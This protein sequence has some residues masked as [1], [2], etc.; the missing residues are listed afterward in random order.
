MERTIRV[1]DIHCDH[2]KHSL[3]GAV[4][5]VRGVQDVRVDIDR[6]TVEVRFDESAT[7]EARIHAAI[8]E[9][10]YAISG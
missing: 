10:G 9:Q 8:E 6:R 7:N 2:C 4:G 5:A 1:P 3:E